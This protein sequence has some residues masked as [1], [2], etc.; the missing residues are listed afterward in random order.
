MSKAK[1][2]DPDHR[3][4]TLLSDPSPIDYSSHPEII[5]SQPAQS[6]SM[7]RKLKVA[8]AQVGA[9]H[10]STPRKEVLQRLIALL[11]QAAAE[12]VQLVVFREYL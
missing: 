11:E 5:R 7:A 2:R 8:A 6:A 3:P 1:K 9:V 10:R 12:D 4:L